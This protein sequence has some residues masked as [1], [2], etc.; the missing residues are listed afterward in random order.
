MARSG[1]DGLTYWALRQGASPESQLKADN[2]RAKLVMQRR[3][4]QAERS[5][6]QPQ[7]EAVQNVID[8]SW[9]DKLPACPVYYPTK[10]EFEDPMDY[11]Q[12]IIPEASKYGICKVV[13]PLVASVPAGCVLTR[14][15]SGFKF[16]PR[17]QPMRLSNWDSS[18]MHKFLISGQ[19]YTFHEYEKMA[20][21]FYIR[22]FGST[23]CLPPKFMEAEFWKELNNGKINVEYGS[24]IEGSAFS[25]SPNDI[26]GMSK[27]NLN[28]FSHLADST[29]RLLDTAIP[30]VTEPMLYIG[31]AFAMFAWH[32]EDHYLFS[33]NYHHSGA[34]KT[35]YGVP[36]ESAPY[37]EQVVQDN[38]YDKELLA[39]GQEG[40]AYDLLIGKTTMFSPKLLIEHGVPTYRAIQSPGEFIITFPRA[41]HSGF[42]HG[43]NCTEAVNFTMGDW[44]PF[45]AAA[46]A[47]YELLKRIPLLPHEELLCKEAITVG[48][49]SASVSFKGRQ[50]TTS[51]S[52]NARKRQHSVKVAFVRL[53]RFQHQVR[54]LLQRLGAQI[55]CRSPGFDGSVMCVLCKRMCYLAFVNCRCSATP[56]CLNHANEIRECNC[57]T[58]RSV[59]VR[60]GLQDLEEM[61]LRFEEEDAVR[62]EA[63][64]QPAV[65]VS[66]SVKGII[67]EEKL[68][69]NEDYKGYVPLGRLAPVKISI[70]AQAM[71]SIHY[72]GE[73]RAVIIPKA[74]SE[75]PKGPLA[76]AY[77]GG[78]SLLSSCPD[79]VLPKKHR[80][81]IRGAPP[82]FCYDG[83]LDDSESDW[84]DESG[85]LC[86]RT[87]AGTVHLPASAKRKRSFTVTRRAAARSTVQSRSRG[88]H[89]EQYDDFDMSS[90]DEDDDGDEEYWPS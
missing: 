86:E 46:C 12:K 9:A 23:A 27:W 65:D 48:E 73:K 22:R 68:L 63:H 43:F 56:M 66:T 29:L 36:G 50:E 85:G 74:G 18:D 13:S 81:L 67:M 24:D 5:N 8:M 3:R 19:Q 39:A 53:V 17:V 26:L 71:G 69:N 82:S 57:G 79:T 47:R 58:G 37:F 38:V 77:Q 42:S 11:I 90:E 83:N 40:L 80:E 62:T 30:G 10:K 49:S 34:P 35:W 1:G 54:W 44:F 72:A 55:I 51:I 33:I 32:V 7:V 14:E 64:S 60:E 89:V 21:K 76:V 2:L 4:L 16:T 70:S 59:V 52:D 20:N 78:Q 45:G 88:G 25:S 41:Y 84:G 87:S 15:K 61:V 75:S 6:V 28:N 31:M